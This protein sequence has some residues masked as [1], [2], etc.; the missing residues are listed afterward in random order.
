MANR[1]KSVIL[2]SRMDLHTGIHRSLLQ[3]PPRGYGFRLKS[4]RHVFLFPTPEILSPHASPHDAEFCDYGKGREIVHSAQ[5]PVLNR[6]RWIT[7]LSDAAYLL[8]GRHSYHPRAGREFATGLSDDMARSIARRMRCL[9]SAFLHPSCK[10]VIFRT[11]QHVKMM[12]LHFGDWGLNGLSREFFAKS[13]V[14]YPAQKACPSAVVKRKWK[15]GAMRLKIVFCARLFAAKNGAT[16]LRIF[17]RLKKRHPD[18]D[19]VYIGD[20]PREERERYAKELSSIQYEPLLPRAEVMEI[21]SRSHVFLHTAPSEGFGMIFAE[22]MAAGMAIV[23]GNEPQRMHTGEIIGSA[24]GAL[25]DRRELSAEKVEREFEKKL[26]SLITNPAR[27]RRMGLANYEA[28]RSG[29]VSVMRRNAA[30]KELYDRALREKEGEILTRRDV[31][32]NAEGRWA[33]LSE[34]GLAADLSRCEREVKG[35]STFVALKSKVG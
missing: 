5:W 27:A 12:K 32:G 3:I 15:A 24:G 30:L 22:A 23:A 16:A 9:I 11:E 13:A 8:V 31:L 20:I 25:L 34:T 1:K 17:S 7:D 18:V 10:G 28:A 19:F 4:A 14:I 6:S 29:K 33:S 35:F 2:G 21:L 26:E